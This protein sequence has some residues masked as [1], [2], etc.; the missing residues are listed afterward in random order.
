MDTQADGQKP[1]DIPMLITTSRLVL[2]CLMPGDGPDYKN[3]VAESLVDLRAFPAASWPQAEPSE[4]EAETFCGACVSQHIQK[5]RFRFVVT[6]RATREWAGLIDLSPHDWSVP[7]CQI[8]YWTRSSL[9]KQGIATEALTAVT[10]FALNTLHMQR[11]E[12]EVDDKHTASRIVCERVGYTLEGVMRN[13]R[14][15]PDGTLRDTRLYAIATP[16]P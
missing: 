12:L 1:A 13:E 6:L 11:I 3:M 5:T 2:R 15:D 14:A 9:K 4:E 10:E 7:K 8:G 16:K